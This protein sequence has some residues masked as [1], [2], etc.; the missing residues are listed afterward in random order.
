VFTRWYPLD[1]SKR[2]PPSLREIHR[3]PASDT[4][5]PNIK[6]PPRGTQYNYLGRC[7]GDT[8]QPATRPGQKPRFFP[9]ETKLMSE[10]RP[11]AGFSNGPEAAWGILF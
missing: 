3:G 10:K 11:Q 4:L 9:A 7:L 2:N 6:T 5:S 1:S 8:A